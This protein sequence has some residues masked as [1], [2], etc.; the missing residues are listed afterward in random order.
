MRILFLTH[1]FPP[2][3]NAPANRVYE[4]CRRWVKGGDEVHVITGVPNV[5]TGTIYNGYK[6][7]LIQTETIDD[8][9]T[10]RVWTYIAPNK[11]KIR[12]IL[13]YMSY[14]IS[15]SLAGLF[16]QKPDVVIATSPQFFCGWAGV[17][18][19]RMKRV[20]FIL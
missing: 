4:H 10:T 5:P 18:I 16:A 7:R 9:K 3:G 20:P 17:F 6:N 15:A 2:E 8:I 11:G 12:R 19:S 14:M 1:Y 13:N